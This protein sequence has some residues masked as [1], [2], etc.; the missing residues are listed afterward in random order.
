MTGDSVS[1][2]N[3]ALVFA[4]PA[5]SKAESA[6]VATNIFT[7]VFTRKWGS[8]GCMQTRVPLAT[9]LA[10]S[11]IEVCWGTPS[12]ALRQSEPAAPLGAAVMRAGSD[13]ASVTVVRTP[14][15]PTPRCAG[16]CPPL[17][18]P[19]PLPQG[20]WFS[21]SGAPRSPILPACRP[22]P[23]DRH[24]TNRPSPPCWVSVCVSHRKSRSLAHVCAHF[25]V[26]SYPG[27]REP[28]SELQE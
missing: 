15:A 6:P 14:V 24:A 19:P 18:R 21:R 1:A 2:S 10:K 8:S 26:G 16:R 4:P 20:G 27:V 13:S 28:C 12:L 3:V 7:F 9:G 22:P 17:P 23:S 25:T 5:A 11:S